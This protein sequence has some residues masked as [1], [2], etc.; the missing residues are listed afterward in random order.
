MDRLLAGYRRFRAETWPADRARYQAL[1]EQGQRPQTLVVSCSDSRVDPATVFGAAPGELFVIRN[2]AGVVPRYRPDGGCHGTSAALEF[3]V[4]VLRVARIVVLGHAQCGGVRAMVE[5]APPEASDF[6]A[7]WMEAAAAALPPRAA[8]GQ[9]HD[10]VLAEAELAVVR[11]SLAN[12]LSFPWIARVVE[13]GTLSLYGMQFDIHTGVLA[14]VGKN[15]L[16]ALK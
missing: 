1:S 8:A 15:G 4:R 10:E 5:G 14:T 11:A 13:A 3:G 16:E 9:S 7:P 6:V 2:V 12:L